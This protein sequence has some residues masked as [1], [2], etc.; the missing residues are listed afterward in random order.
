MGVDN[1]KQFAKMSLIRFGIYKKRE[2]LFTKDY[3][4]AYPNVKVGQ[5]TYGKP[6]LLFSSASNL[7]IGKFCSIADEVEIFLGGNHRLDWIST[8]PF[9]EI[10]PFAKVASNITGHPSTK[11]DVIIGNDVWIGRGVKLMSG[12][13]VGDGSVIAA[14]SVVTKNIG[15]YELWGGVPAKFIRK[16]F[17]DD[18][19]KTL[20]EIKWWDWD[21]SKIKDWT[22]VLCSSNMIKM[23]R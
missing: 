9:N 16:R 2:S 22:E 21:V 7:E 1:F 20:L 3:F 13:K 23:F 6:K 4:R 8:Y 14:Y 12:V 5:F 17:S 19:I 18:E 15:D 10:E 11:G